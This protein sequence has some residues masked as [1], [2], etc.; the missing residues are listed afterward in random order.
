MKGKNTSHCGRVSD[1]LRR[2]RG[3]HGVCLNHGSGIRRSCRGLSRS[4][5]HTTHSSPT[6]PNLPI[7]GPY[8]VHS[9]SVTIEL[10]NQPGTPTLIHG[11]RV[12]AP[13]LN[14]TH[15]IPC[16]KVRRST[17]P[18]QGFNRTS[19]SADGFKLP[20]GRCRVAQDGIKLPGNRAV[21]EGSGFGSTRNPYHMRTV[22]SEDP[23]T[24]TPRGGTTRRLFTKSVWAGV[25]ERTSFVCQ[26]IYEIVF[27][28]A[29]NGF[30]LISQTLM[31]S[32]ACYL[33]RS[34]LSYDCDKP[35][36]R[37]QISRRSFRCFQKTP[38]Q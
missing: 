34:K 4:K 16:M 33:F 10:A 27:A 14:N 21:S 9:S 31:V 36:P 26:A 24:S 1:C 18:C 13:D 17:V 5:I 25:V 20:Q 32:R 7:F 22:L 15:T 8:F 23:D 38:M 2:S 30:T 28:S 19:M 6:T 37:T 12:D 11:I 29:G 3:G 35:Y